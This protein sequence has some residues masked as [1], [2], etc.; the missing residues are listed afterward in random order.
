M[1]KTIILIAEENAL[2]VNFDGFL[3]RRRFVI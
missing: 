3:I 1:R 2:V